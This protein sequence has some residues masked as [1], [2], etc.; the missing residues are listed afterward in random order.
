[1]SPSRVVG[2]G[3]VLVVCVGIAILLWFYRPSIAV[4]YVDILDPRS[5]RSSWTWPVGLG[6]TLLVVAAALW[7]RRRRHV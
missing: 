1:M 4:A 2:L 6:I 5:G 3:G 7:W